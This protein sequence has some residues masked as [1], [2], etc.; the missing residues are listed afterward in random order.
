MSATPA[1]RDLVPIARVADMERSLEFY[2]QLGFKVVGKYEP[3][4]QLKWAYLR[5]GSADLMLT[6]ADQPVNPSAQ[7]IVFYVYVPGVAAFRE[8]LVARG[9]EVGELQ[10]FFFAKD[11]EFRIVDPDGYVLLVSQAAA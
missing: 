11:G 8:Q 9:L 1:M 3:Q 10:H 4:G 2:D 7:G 5:S 6:L